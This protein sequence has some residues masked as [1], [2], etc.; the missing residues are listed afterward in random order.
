M[1]RQYLDL[2]REEASGQ[3]DLPFQ[4]ASEALA[5]KSSRSPEM[6]RAGDVGCSVLV[7]TTGIAQVEFSIRDGPVRLGQRMVV[8]DGTIRARRADGSKAQADKV[9]L[10]GSEAGQLVRG[11]YFR[12]RFL[13]L[14]FFFQPSVETAKRCGVLDVG[15]LDPYEST[16]FE[17]NCKTR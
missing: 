15:V 13:G 6:D 12:Y 1:V 4:Y 7:L 10:L 8:D 3:V 5:F 9:C 11:G 16:V 2:L 17:L 14:D